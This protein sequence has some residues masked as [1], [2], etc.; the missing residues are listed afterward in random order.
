VIKG[1]EYLKAR[2]MPADLSNYRQAGRDA[3]E[4]II[5]H[6]TD[7]HANPGPVAAM[8]QEPH[9]GSSAHFVIGQDGSVVQAVSLRDVAFHAHLANRASV[10]IEHCCRTPGELGR[11]DNGLPPSEALLQAGA[12]LV[13]WLCHRAKL[14]IN[15]QTIMGHAEADKDTTHRGCPTSAG[16]DLDAYVDRVLRAYNF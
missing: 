5:I 11:D 7:G 10:G 13:A 14:P 3:Y 15:R 6:C 8:W 1:A 9:H 2:W 12:Q 16:I 4:R